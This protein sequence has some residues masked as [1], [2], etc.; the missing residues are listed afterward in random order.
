[1][2]L[3]SG[4]AERSK[5]MANLTFLDLMFAEA[6]ASGLAREAAR[7]ERPPPDN[8]F[9]LPRDPDAGWRKIKEASKKENMVV[10]I[11]FTDNANDNC[12]T[13]QGIFMD[14]AR[15]FENIPFVRVVIAPGATYNEVYW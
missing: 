7:T 4:S 3:I 5:K 2:H 14:L 10:C 13:A 6:L 12:R 8:F 11:E 15:E 9:I 1:M